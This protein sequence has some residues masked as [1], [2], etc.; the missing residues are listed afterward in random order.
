LSYYAHH[1]P[2]LVQRLS[3][4]VMLIIQILGPLLLL[5]P[6]RLRHVGALAII[7][8]MLVIALTGNYGYFNLLTAALAVLAF[9]DELLSR[10]RRIP[11]MLPVQ[12][13]SR[14]ARILAVLVL[15]L[16]GSMFVEQKVGRMAVFAPLHTLGNW[17]SP[18]R[19]FNRYGLFAVMT[20][21]RPELV[22]EGSM[23]GR[24]WEPYELP[25]K[26]GELSRCPSFVAP[27]MPRLDWQLWFAAL[28]PKPTR[29]HSAWLTGLLRGLLTGREPVVGLFA[30]VPF[31]A[32]PKQ[33]RIR[34]YLYRFAGRNEDAWWLRD[35]PTMYLRPVTLRSENEIIFAQPVDGVGPNP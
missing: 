5:A 1:L 4:V 9:D 8:L 22:I 18:L 13:A 31:E 32:P 30:R 14:H 24:S 33:L 11:A 15:A 17:L 10:W 2:D 27:H 19:S 28:N 16:T 7:G 29:R 3:C 26:P 21:E 34:R 23:D 20:M 35:T 6:R 12:P 25:Y